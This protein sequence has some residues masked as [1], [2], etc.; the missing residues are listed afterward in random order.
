MRFGWLGLVR[1]RGR[2]DQGQALALE[3]GLGGLAQPGRRL[4]A[5]DVL[6]QGGGVGE[7]ALQ[8]GILALD[9]G[10][11]QQQALV[12]GEVGLD[13]GAL[14]EAGREVAADAGELGLEGDV[15]GV[16]R[17]AGALPAAAAG[18]AT[19][20]LSSMAASS[21]WAWRTSGWSSV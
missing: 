3:L 9:R 13:L 5:G 10:R 15:G 21:R 11:A 19:R 2:L 8:A 20:S 7:L 16:G 6:A 4:L 14:G 17:A 18:P 1:Q 12:G